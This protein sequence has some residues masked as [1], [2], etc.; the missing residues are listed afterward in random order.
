MSRW[1]KPRSKISNDSNV[2]IPYSGPNPRTA[3]QLALDLKI[4][5]QIEI[6]GIGMGVLNDGTAFLNGRGS[7]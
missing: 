4:E 3:A 2:L 6:D 5:K 7:K 1:R